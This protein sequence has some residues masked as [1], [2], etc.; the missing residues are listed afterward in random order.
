MTARDADPDAGGGGGE[1]ALHRIRQPAGEGGDGDD[2]RRRGNRGR[3]PA[4]TFADSG[5]VT[6]R[7]RTADASTLVARRNHEPDMGLGRRLVERSDEGVA[8]GGTDEL[9]L[10]V[11][12]VLVDR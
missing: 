12:T 11:E 2:G 6:G 7:R 5:A 3:P 10:G 1:A 8:D 9:E 4:V